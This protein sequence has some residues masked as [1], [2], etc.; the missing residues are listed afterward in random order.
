MLNSCC[1]WMILDTHRLCLSICG[2]N[3]VNHVALSLL[4]AAASHWNMVIM[5]AARAVYQ[6]YVV[7]GMQCKGVSCIQIHLQAII[8][9]VSSKLLYFQIR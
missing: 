7:Y 3:F 1:H 9:Q 2:A 5:S 6:R 8:S 4:L